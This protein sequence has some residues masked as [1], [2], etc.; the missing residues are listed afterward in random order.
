MYFMLIVQQLEPQTSDR[1]RKVRTML[2][3]N[4]TGNR[5]ENYIASGKTTGNCKGDDSSQNGNG[6]NNIYFVIFVGFACLVGVLLIVIG[7]LFCKN[8]MLTCKMNT[9]NIDK[10]TVGLDIEEPND[11]ISDGNSGQMTQPM[12][13]HK[14]SGGVGM[15]QSIG[16]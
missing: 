11:N 5:F 14:S 1:T 4:S 8:K 12:K 15:Y 3:S 16:L 7:V 13:M 2:Q 9:N 10:G 6:I